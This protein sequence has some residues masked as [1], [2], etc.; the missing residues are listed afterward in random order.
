MANHWYPRT[1]KP[2]T[3]YCP[4]QVYLGCS[5]VKI[6]QSDS[7]SSPLSSYSNT[8][9]VRN[10]RLDQLVIG[11]MPW[12]VLPKVKFPFDSSNPPKDAWGIQCITDD[13]LNCIA[14]EPSNPSPG[15]PRPNPNTCYDCLN[16]NKTCP[17]N[18]YCNWFNEKALKFPADV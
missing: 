13:W 4:S 15:N 9:P 18:C 10:K 2:L 17:Q 11:C 14:S 7:Y 5:D 8:V 6:A 3:E 12:H 16:K 1:T